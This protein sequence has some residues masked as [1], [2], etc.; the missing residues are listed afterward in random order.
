MRSVWSGALGF[1]LVNIPVKL[2]TAI[3]TSE[4]DLDMLDRRDFANIRFK[5]VNEKTG[6]EVPWENIVKAY[7]YEGQYVVLEDDDFEQANAKKTKMIDIEDF[8]KLEE[9]DSIYYESS[10]YVAPEATGNKAYS[11]LRQALLKTGKVGLATFVMR[12]KE[13]LALVRA[14]DKLIILH[15]LHFPEEIR[16]TAELKLP[17]NDTF[18]PKELDI[19]VTLIDQQTATFDTAKFQNTYAKDLMAII[20]RKAKGIKKQPQK[21]EIVHSTSSDLI[22][23]LKASLNMKRNKAS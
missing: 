3:E 6:S 16:D 20:E 15:R 8:V 5:R 22:E 21:M 11:L 7:N 13:K 12:S 1:G 14:T 18:K 2:Y 19:A 23:Q 4:L 9:V 17:E 10:Y